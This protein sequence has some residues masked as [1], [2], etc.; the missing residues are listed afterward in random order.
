MCEL[1]ISILFYHRMQILV[2]V[3]S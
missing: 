2:L 1:Y 3:P